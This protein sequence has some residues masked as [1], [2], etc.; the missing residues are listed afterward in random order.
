M[1][2]LT[3]MEGGRVSVG[4][5]QALTEEEAKRFLALADRMGRKLKAKVLTRESDALKAEQ[6]VGVLAI[7]GRTLEI[8][9]KVDGGRVR[10]ALLHMI[11]VAQGMKVADAELAA[12][13][14]QRYD[15]L[16]LFIQLFVQRLSVAVR[17]GLPRRYIGREEDLPVLRG[18]LN[19]VRQFTQL[20]V[21]PDVLAC[22]YDELS[23]DTPLNRVLKAAVKRLAGVARTAANTRRLAELAARFEFVGD[24]AYPLREPVQRDRTNTAFHDL[25]Q[26]A[27]LFLAD[28]SQTTTRGEATG[29]T[30]LFEMNMLFEKFIGRSLQ[31]ELGSDHHVGLKE[32]YHSALR[33]TK[34]KKLFQLEPDVLIDMPG[35]IVLDTKWKR[36]ET[37]AKEERRKLGVKPPDVYQ[38][39]AYAR[40]YGAKRVILLYPWHKDL[41]AAPGIMAHWWAPG[42]QGEHIPF[43]I[44]TVNVGSPETVPATLCEIVDD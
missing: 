20:A 28:E 39:L 8:L 32:K 2:P 23:E 13:A 26:M 33:D 1:I 43:D 4:E 30:L 41:P 44:A 40:A 29:F 10:H 7:P 11:A 22:R 9:P 21:R 5:G 36:L 42:P 27:R 6:V 37:N 24:S 31:R 34:C 38:L 14:T 3:C 16:E 15:L 25:Y 12:L 17:R 35:G 19:V 18:R